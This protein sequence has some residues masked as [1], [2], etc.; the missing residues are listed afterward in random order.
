MALILVVA[1]YI[2]ISDYSAI[3]EE[4]THQLQT[5]ILTNDKPHITK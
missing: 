5:I 1:T 4:E 2:Q 3:Y